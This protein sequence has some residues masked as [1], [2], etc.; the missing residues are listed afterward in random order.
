MWPRPRE[1]SARRLCVIKRVNPDPQILRVARMLY[2]D[3]ARARARARNSRSPAKVS[4]V[5]RR[6]IGGKPRFIRAGMHA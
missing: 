5:I 4:R 3:R 6:A 2:G 1:S